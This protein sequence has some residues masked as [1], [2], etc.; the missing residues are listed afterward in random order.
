MNA[1]DVPVK[2]RMQFIDAKGIVLR[3]DELTFAAT[4][5]KWRLLSTTTG[6][7]VNAGHYRVVLSAADMDGLALDALEVQ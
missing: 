6:S 4:P 7:Y 2:V 5:G 1:T 3:N